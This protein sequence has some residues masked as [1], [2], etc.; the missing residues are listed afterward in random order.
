MTRPNK[1]VFTQSRPLKL[2]IGADSLRFKRADL[3]RSNQVFTSRSYLLP[4]SSALRLKAYLNENTLFL[5]PFGTLE[6][7]DVLLAFSFGDAPTVNQH[8]QQIALDC[9]KY[10]PSLP[11]FLQ[12]EIADDV[13]LTSRDIYSIKAEAYQTTTDVAVAALSLTPKRKVMI[14]A[15]AW[16]AQRCIDTCKSLGWDVIGLRCSNLFPK[17]DPQPWVRHPL[18]WVIKESHREQAAG[19]EISEQFQLI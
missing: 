4:R 7:A 10:R 16:H 14:V 1:I 5:Q 2:Q 18:N 8:L 19:H 6:E 3:P 15:Q 17:D 13:I 12:Q 9:R 11:L